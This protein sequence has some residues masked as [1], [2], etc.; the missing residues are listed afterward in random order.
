V[1]LEAFV[2]KWLVLSALMISIWQVAEQ[3]VLQSGA[4]KL[5]KASHVTVLTTKKEPPDPPSRPVR[6]AEYCFRAIMTLLLPLMLQQHALAQVPIFE[7]QKVLS[8]V[9]DASFCGIFPIRNVILQDQYMIRLQAEVQDIL[10][11][12]LSCEEYGYLSIKNVGLK[13]PEMVRHKKAVIIPQ[14]L[15][16]CEYKMKD[17]EMLRL[18]AVI[19]PQGLLE[20]ESK[21]RIIVSSRCRLFSQPY[22]DNNE[23]QYTGD[24]RFMVDKGSS[25][26]KLG[27][28]QDNT[29]TLQM[30]PQTKFHRFKAYHNSVL[31]EEKAQILKAYVESDDNKNLTLSQKL[32]FKLHC[33]LG[34]HS[35]KHIQ[36]LARRGWLSSREQTMLSRT[37]DVPHCAACIMG[38][39]VRQSSGN[40]TISAIKSSAL[41]QDTL[42]PGQ[43]VYS[44]QFTTSEIGQREEYTGESIY[45]DATSKG[46]SPSIMM[47]L[48]KERVH[49]L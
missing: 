36:Y 28:G 9:Q 26:F 14:G 32:W 40:T 39:Q 49:L 44:D 25:C 29:L 4:W 16:E 46:E 15:L 6:G 22:K 30:D 21:M 17:P 13:D 12:L 19:I 38:K 8:R 45:Y 33:R 43:V 11:D 23:G 2:E 3:F 37:I 1:I 20:C 34:H 35:S 42:P 18:K 47:Q 7:F 27:E 31:T 10:Q 24:Y 5:N 48:L 41:S